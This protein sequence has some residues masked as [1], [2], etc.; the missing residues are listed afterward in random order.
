[1]ASALLGNIVHRLSGSVESMLQQSQWLLRGSFRD[2]RKM[3]VLL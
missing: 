3:Y 2:G 1:L